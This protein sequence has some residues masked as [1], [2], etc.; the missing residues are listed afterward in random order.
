MSDA[1]R[2]QTLLVSDD[3]TEDLILKEDTSL[4]PNGMLTTEPYLNYV[5]EV[6]HHTDT[7]KYKFR[8]KLLIII[9]IIL[10]IISTIFICLYFHEKQKQQ[11]KQK[12]T[13]K[14]CT[15]SGCVEAAAFIKASMD[16]SIDPCEDFY[17]Y[18]CAGWLTKNPIPDG[19]SRWG[20]NSVL[21][22]KNQIIMKAILQNVTVK[23]NTVKSKAE[24]NSFMLYRSCMDMK[25][26][27]KL[28]AKS[29]LDMLH[30]IGVFLKKGTAL[31]GDLQTLLQKL[32]ANTLMTTLFNYAIVPDEKDSERNIIKVCHFFTYCI[33]QKSVIYNFNFTGYIYSEDSNVCH[34]KQYIYIYIFLNFD[35]P[36]IFNPKIQRFF[37]KI[38]ISSNY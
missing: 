16:E 38:S 28:G 8:L 15:T 10:L 33:L 35:F 25:K 22:E 13:K 21:S 9:I 18:S 4:S 26:I 29:L 32:F 1:A 14:Y 12:Q 17:L 7:R 23:E 6:P 5:V 3:S 37:M 24:F 11:E 31:K 27:E 36:Y 30:N 2:R 34:K 20:I 19:R